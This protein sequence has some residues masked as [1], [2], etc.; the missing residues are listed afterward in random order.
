MWE[1]LRVVPRSGAETTTAKAPSSLY[2]APRTDDA[3]VRD[4]LRAAEETV[5][6]LVV[7]YIHW[8]L[9]HLRY[10]ATSLTLVFVI[11]ALLLLSYPIRPEAGIEAVFFALVGAAIVL[12]LV[13]LFQINRDEVLSA[14]QGTA[15]GR[16]TW[17]AGFATNLLVY[18]AIPLVTLLSV[19]FPQVRGVL[20]AWVLP[21]LRALGKG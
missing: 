9:R 20:S 5:A 10:L 17:D 11:G 19:E 18:V 8:T 7:D 12:L 16:V 2:A 1:A 21:A 3:S 15:V 6:V 13:I 14:I 4:L